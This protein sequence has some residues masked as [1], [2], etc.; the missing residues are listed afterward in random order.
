MTTDTKGQ[1]RAHWLQVVLIGRNPVFTVVRIIIIVAVVF[2]SRAYILEPIRIKGP[3]M[4][5][6]YREKGV[7]FVNRLAYRHSDPKRGDVV[8]IRFAGPNVMLMKRVIGLPGET[9]E[10]RD[11]YVYINGTKLDEP[12]IDRTNYPTDWDMEP[13]KL[14]ADQYYVVGDNRSMPKE[15]HEEG[16]AARERII[17]RILL[18][19]N[20]FVSSSAPR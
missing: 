16:V 18:C 12:Y 13:K 17:G 20:L 2:I 6:T 19:K 1:R 14:G 4:L 10:F 7:N 11:G 9:I 5:P 15:L 8:A 3:S